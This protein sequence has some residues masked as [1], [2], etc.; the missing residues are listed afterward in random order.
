MRGLRGRFERSGL[1]LKW[2]VPGLFFLTFVFSTYLCPANSKLE[3]FNK[4]WRRLDLLW[5][6]K[7]GA[8]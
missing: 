4:N 2:A 5:L 7:G 3:K 8:F 6:T 1:I